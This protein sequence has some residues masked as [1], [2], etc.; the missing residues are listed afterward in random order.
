MKRIVYMF[1]LLGSVLC[2]ACS[3]NKPKSAPN[4]IGKLKE[5]TKTSSKVMLNPQWG[6]DGLVGVKDGSLVC[7][8]SHA[9]FFYYVLDGKDFSLEKSFGVKGNGRNEWVAPC[10]LLSLEKGISYVLDNGTRKMTTLKNYAVSLV[11][12]SKVDGIANLPQVHGRYLCYSDEKPNRIAF[13]LNDFTTN[14]ALDSVV[15]E[16]S[17]RQGNSYLDAFVYAI[18]GETVV[19]AQN[20]KDCFEVYQLSSDS[21]LRHICEVRGVGQTDE[22]RFVYYSSVALDDSHIYMLSQRHVDV[23]NQSGYSSIEVYDMD[24]KALRNIH[25]DFIAS[26]MVLNPATHSLLLL[27]ALDGNLYVVSV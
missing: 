18:H 26:Q 20:L 17:Q 8:S 13:R 3:D 10:L 12:D 15:F 21:R 9:E 14:E 5:E 27:S 4:E 2:A 19:L 23:G 16:D 6:I 25:L 11:S 24:G 1:C 22:D 7:K